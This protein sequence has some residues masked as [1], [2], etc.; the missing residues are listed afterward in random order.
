M[1]AAEDRAQEAS[2]SS[3]YSLA[4]RFRISSG[5]LTTK[6]TPTIP[7][8]RKVE[9]LPTI[10]E[11]TAF[12]NGTSTVGQ[13]RINFLLECRGNRAQFWPNL[14][15]DIRKLVVSLSTSQVCETYGSRFKTC[16]AHR[17]GMEGI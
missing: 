12:A 8:D 13:E 5:P 17:H 2:C 4:V 6:T 3:I 1:Q 9:V 16:C 14:R 7:R 15:K 10:R 11:N